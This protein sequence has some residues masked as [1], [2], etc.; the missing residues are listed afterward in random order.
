MTPLPHSLLDGGCFDTMT[1]VPT[2]SDRDEFLLG[3]NHAYP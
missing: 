2:A 1:L 3:V